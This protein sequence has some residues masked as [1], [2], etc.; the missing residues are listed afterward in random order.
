MNVPLAREAC[1]LIRRRPVMSAAA[2]LSL[3]LGMTINAA[4]FSVL[5]ALLFRPLPIR[6]PAGLV[7][8]TAGQRSDLSFQD[9]EDL[10]SASQTLQGVAAFQLAGAIEDDGSRSPEVVSL[11]LVTANYF[12]TLGVNAVRG[13][14]VGEIDRA[15]GAAPAVAISYAYWQGHFA[16]DPGIVG[17]AV[18]LNTRPWTIVGVLPE[19]FAGTQPLF[20]PAVWMTTDAAVRNGRKL[21]TRTERWYSVFGR[22]ASGASIEAA[23]AEIAGIGQRLAHDHPDTNL[24]VKLTADFEKNVRVRD[25]SVAIAVAIVLVSLPL[26]IGCANVAGLLL[27]HGESRRKE[28]AIRLSLGAARGQ[29]VRQLLLETSVLSA[30][31]LTASL[32]VAAW[33]LR[34]APAL[35]PPLPISF[36]LDFRIDARIGAISAAIGVAATLMAGL[37]PALVATR[38]DLATLIKSSSSL[39]GKRGD[40]LRSVLVTGQVA[41]S[42]VLVLLSALFGTSL[43]NAKN[44]NSVLPASS[45]AFAALSPGAFGYDAAHVQLFYEALV[46]RARER[47]AIGA[48]ALVRHVPLNSLY[49]GGATQSVV[50]PGVEPPNGQSSL[51]IRQNVVSPGYFATM[52]IPL[53]AGR[54]FSTLDTMNGARVIIINQ[55]MANLYW[56]GGDAVNR[57]ITLVD[58]TSRTRVP[59]TVIG[60]AHDSKY[61]TL[62]ETTPAYLYLPLTQYRAGEMTLITRSALDED[63]L[64]ALTRDLL[65]EIDPAM[66]PVELNTKSQHLRRALFGERLLAGVVTVIGSISLLL[67]VVGLYGVVAS[68]VARR[69]RD[70]GIEMALGATSR[71][72][73]MSTM[74]TGARLTAVGMLIGGALG[75]GLARLFAGALYGVTALSPRVLGSTLIITA[76]VTIA[77]T[78]VP[79]RRAGRV[80][81]IVALRE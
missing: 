47:P 2:V 70:I 74:V 78:F 60:V 40:R 8:V 68:A 38:S 43:I 26:I 59:A 24:S 28:M 33:L 81:P 17:R 23:R 57:A 35:L 7:R 56:P 53:V 29:L 80:D 73:V 72:V 18:R 58:N 76:L 48:A 14:V 25:F 30:L 32:L 4:S 1:R 36:N 63:R 54:D 5:D 75:I 42:F 62:N 67:A 13:R 69:T 20:A 44:Q 27:G 77:A 79:A 55:T 41:M 12:S 50:I 9:F 6:D 10:A 31:A 39:S 34:L 21:G 15:A 66:P 64:A 45:L 51:A 65:R 3:A 37:V 22:L 52:D 11:G 46:E 49:G 19:G 71:R 16:G 61:A